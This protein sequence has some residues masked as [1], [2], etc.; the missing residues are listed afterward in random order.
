[1]KKNKFSA[2]EDKICYKEKGIES[3]ADGYYD[4]NTI[5]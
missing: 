1:M 4:I 5:M 2:Y 3:Y